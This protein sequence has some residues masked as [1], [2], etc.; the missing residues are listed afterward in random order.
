MRAYLGFNTRR[1]RNCERSTERAPWR[2]LYLR[3][4]QIGANGAGMALWVTKGR[5]RT[6]LNES[7]AV[8]EKPKREESGQFFLFR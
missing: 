8:A 1:L 6:L 2:M 7:F 5:A 3:V 4:G